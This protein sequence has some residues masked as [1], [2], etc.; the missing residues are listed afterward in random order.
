MEWH[1]P[2]SIPQ[3]Y[4]LPSSLTSEKWKYVLCAQVIPTYVGGGGG[5]RP[6][7]SK[8]FQC[9]TA[10][11]AVTSVATAQQHDILISRYKAAQ[12]RHVE[13]HF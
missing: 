8:I 2:T 11:D 12:Y 9:Y 1:C 7:L 3:L 13:Q 4:K 5:E 10:C 6:S